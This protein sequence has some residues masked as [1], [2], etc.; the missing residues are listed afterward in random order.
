MVSVKSQFIIRDFSNADRYWLSVR[1]IDLELH[2]N[3]RLNIIRQLIFGYIN[4]QIFTSLSIC[5][6]YGYINLGGLSFF[7][8]D[9]GFFKSGNELTFTELKLKRFAFQMYQKLIRLSMFLC[10]VL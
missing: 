7:H 2:S 4:D 1:L 10:S 8:T 6:F 5:F 9:H 3:F